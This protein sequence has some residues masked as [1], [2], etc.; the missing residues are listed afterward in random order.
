MKHDSTFTVFN[1]DGFQGH[2][3][4]L[5]EINYLGQLSHQNLVKLIG[6][7]LEDEQ[8]LLVYEFMHK[9]CLED[10]LFTNGVKCRPLSWT[11]RVKVALD[12]AKGL[13]FLHSD[14]VKVIYRDIKASKHLAGL[15]SR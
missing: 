1:P 3:E 6:Y 11:L 14:P 10:H 12:A 13:A 4:W 9:G 8:R 7:C 5:I 15:V 2:R